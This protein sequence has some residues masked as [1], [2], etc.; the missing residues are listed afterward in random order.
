MHSLF[1]I[2]LTFLNPIFLLVG[3]IKP[4]RFK[5]TRLKVFLIFIGVTIVSL[6]GYSLTAPKVDLY[7]IN[8]DFENNRRTTDGPEDFLDSALEKKRKEDE[9]KEERFRDLDKSEVKYSKELSAGFYNVGIDIPA[10][11]YDIAWVKGKGNFRTVREAEYG[12]SYTV[13][14]LS[15]TDDPLGTQSLVNV[16]LSTPGNVIKIDSNL[17]VEIKSFSDVNTDLQPRD[18]SSAEHIYLTPGVYTSGIDF[19]PGVY[20]VGHIKDEGTV[21]SVDD[22][23]DGIDE[24]F[25]TDGIAY[26][27]NLSLEEGKQLEIVGCEIELIPA[28]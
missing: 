13:D 25:G 14:L 17:V 8:W 18:N 15:D 24:K 6:I 28:S 16:D 2:I 22:P 12:K 1:S 9:E 10:G 7:K 23:I 26:F 20:T 11:I 21:K 27:D 19:K 3:M 5:L 4:D